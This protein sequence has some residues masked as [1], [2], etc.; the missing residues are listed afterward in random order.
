MMS[1]QSSD[2]IDHLGRLRHC[3][4]LE[5]LRALREDLDVVQDGRALVRVRAEEHLRLM[6]DKRER[7]RVGRQQFIGHE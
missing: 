4:H 6:V 3:R 7:A 1:G 2:G 5:E